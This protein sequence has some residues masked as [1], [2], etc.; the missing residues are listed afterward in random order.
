MAPTVPVSVAIYETTGIKHYSLYLGAENDAEKTILHILGARQRYFPQ[1][2]TPA[3]APDSNIDFIELHRLCKIDASSIENVKT[4]AWGTPIRNHEPDYSCQDY[5]LDVLANL[6]REAIV[7][8][9]NNGFSTNLEGL[10]SKRES[11]H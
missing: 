6:V 8:K 7:D 4:V 3:T 1:I 11:W 5:V 10:K 9:T 2:I